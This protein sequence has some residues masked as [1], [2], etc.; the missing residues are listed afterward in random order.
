MKLIMNIL[1]LSFSIIASE[2]TEIPI[3]FT[4]GFWYDYVG[5]VKCNN[6]IYLEQEKLVTNSSVGVA[7]I[8]TVETTDSILSF[9]IY[10]LHAFEADPTKYFFNFSVDTLKWIEFYATTDTTNCERVL[11]VNTHDTKYD[12]AHD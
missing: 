1:I 7:N 2:P 3:E 10:I 5:Y 9:E 11:K 8:F 6:E 4:Y 12:P